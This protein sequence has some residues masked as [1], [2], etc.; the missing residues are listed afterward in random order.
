VCARAYTYFTDDVDNPQPELAA[1][2]PQTLLKDIP[3]VGS[4]LT[5]VEAYLENKS[6][7]EIPDD[8]TVA[9]LARPQR[10]CVLVAFEDHAGYRGPTGTSA[11]GVI[12][13]FA[14]TL[15]DLISTVI[16]PVTDGEVDGIVDPEA[17]VD[18]VFK[19]LFGVAPDPP[20]AIYRDGQFSGI[21]ESNYT[22]HKG[23][24][25][26]VMTGGKSPKLVNDLQTFGI[27]F[28]LSQLQYVI[29]AGGGVGF[30]GAATVD[31]AGPP[32]GSGL[33]ELYQG[34]LDNKL[35]AWQRY[36]DPLRALYTGDMGYLESFERGNTAYTI[37]AILSLRQGNWKTRPFR[38][39]NTS[40]MQSKPYIIYYDVLL[41]DRV[42][43]EQDGIIYVD[44]VHAIKYEYDRQKPITF[45]V[46]VGDDTNDQDPFSQGIKALQGLG[47][48]IGAVVGMDT[49]FG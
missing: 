12:N 49:I 36:T 39:F 4:V 10:P 40:I 18:P 44:Q 29:S 3:I 1:L 13:L 41:D 37:S 45:T 5:A 38:S 6:L 32:I 34:Q 31:A 16:F 7:D 9:D 20:W 14:S 8:L 48:L 27:K 15:D 26:T 22:Q 46:S 19:R 25:K 33:E 43:F 2:L 23:P 35:F 30:G 28:G 24:V 42:G 21:I 17:P 11:D 47:A